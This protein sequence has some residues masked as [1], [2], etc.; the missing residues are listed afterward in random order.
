[1]EGV[2]LLLRHTTKAASRTQ[3][4]RGPLPEHVPSVFEGAHGVGLRAARFLL[5]PETVDGEHDL[6]PAGAYSTP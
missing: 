1:M 6:S 3:L 4:A 2:E 5:I